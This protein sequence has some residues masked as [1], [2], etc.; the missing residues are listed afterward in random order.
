MAKKRQFYGFNPEKRADGL[1]VTLEEA[2]LELMKKMPEYDMH[3]MLQMDEDHF[4]AEAHHSLGRT[5]RNKWIHI[6]MS[7]MRVWF[8]NSG[9]EHPDDMS[10]IILHCFYRYAKGMPLRLDDLVNKKIEHW[11][12]WNPGL[13]KNIRLK[14]WNS[15]L[16][17]MEYGYD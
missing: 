9:I 14:Y 2:V 16:R 1:P 11:N 15:D 17:K 3:T 13:A 5:I 6:P 7:R 8:K 4:M 10:S 12:E